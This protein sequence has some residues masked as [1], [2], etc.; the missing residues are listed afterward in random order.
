MFTYNRT[1]EYSRVNAYQRTITHGT[2][3]HR[4]LVANSDIIANDQ[5]EAGVAV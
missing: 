1:I 5:R 2:S 4:R 3:M